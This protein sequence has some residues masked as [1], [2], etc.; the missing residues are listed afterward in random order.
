[1]HNEYIE[2]RDGGYYVA[3]TRISLD[4]VVYSFNAGNSPEAIQDDFPLLTTAQIC[5]AIAFYLD[6]KAQVGEYLAGTER[7]FEASGI[8]LKQADP[9]LWER[10]QRARAKMGEPRAR[11]F[12]SRQM[13]T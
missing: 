8:P 5:G 6:H 3:G 12:A 13:P 2:D 9:A 10:L 1:M 7:E 11:V 4:S